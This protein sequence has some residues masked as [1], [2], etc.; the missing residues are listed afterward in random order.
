MTDRRSYDPFAPPPAVDPVE[1]HE[2]LQTLTGV[3][4]PPEPA[5]QEPAEPEGPVSDYAAELPAD[6]DDISKPDLIALAELAGVATYGTKA[7]IAARIR[8]A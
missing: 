8:A 1:A 6:L 2:T 4:Q 7:E 5:E 3:V